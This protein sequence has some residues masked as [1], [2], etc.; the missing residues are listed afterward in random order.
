M[1]DDKNPWEEK[2]KFG[3]DVAKSEYQNEIQRFHELDN[4]LN[5]L[6]VVF[7]CIVTGIGFVI[8]EFVGMLRTVSIVL[9]CIVITLLVL[10]LAVIIGGFFP[11]DLKVINTEQFT[12]AEFY[13]EKSQIDF[14]SGIIAGYENCIKQL[15]RQNTAKIVCL[16]IAYFL[17]GVAFVLFGII[18][19]MII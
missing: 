11:R 19:L 9:I 12:E 15:K 18:I 6:L 4:K 1:E 5:M 10:S 2:L 3:L 7:V 17:L 16:K 13:E 8:P 14:L